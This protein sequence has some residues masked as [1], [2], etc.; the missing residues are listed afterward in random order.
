MDEAKLR[1]KLQKIETLFAGATTPVEYRLNPPTVRAPSCTVGGLNA[2]A[3]ALR[4]CEQEQPQKR[5]RTA[6]RR[7]CSGDRTPARGAIVIP[8]SG[9]TG[10]RT[11]RSFASGAGPCRRTGTARP[12]LGLADTFNANAL[13]A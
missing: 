6:A 3:S 10:A 7:V 8:T 11:T 2:S 1:E 5:Q 4:A 9:A 13:R 12:S